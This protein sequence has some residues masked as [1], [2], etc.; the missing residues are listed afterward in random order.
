MQLS[1]FGDALKCGTDQ[2]ALGLH[3]E[4]IGSLYR[5]FQELKRWSQKI[6]LIARETEDEVIVEKHFVD[7]LAVLTLLEPGAD[8]LLDIGSG[9]GF[10]GLACKAVRPALT[11]GLME[12]RL[13]RV[14]FLKHVIR[15]CGL[16][17]IRVYAQRLEQNTETAELAGY[18]CLVSRAVTD[19]NGFLD[20]CSIL[21][22]RETSVI[23][24]K[25]PNY[26]RELDG[27]DGGKEG[28]DLVEKRIY[29]LPLSGSSRV[30]LVFR[31]TEDD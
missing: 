17:G 2:F 27:D 7:S 29:Q 31:K 1:K 22:D 4:Q 15:T 23:C 19:I 21:A 10:P 16:D 26:L 3:E 30:L 8:A 24:M 6:N 5:Y 14:S 13:K 11:V 9:A 12:P 20:M 25:G 18:N 28:W